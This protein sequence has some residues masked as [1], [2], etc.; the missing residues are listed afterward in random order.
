[1][2]TR[3]SI[4]LAAAFAFA[5][6]PSMVFA[7]GG[8]SHVKLHIN[9]RWSECSFQLDPSLTQSAWTKFTREA[10]LVAYFRSLT[11]A[12]PIGVGNFELSMHRWGTAVNDADPAW[13][14][15]FV[16]PDSVHWLKEGDR[17]EFP[18]LTF[19]TGLA[20]NV[21]IG[22]YW[23]KNPNA[24]Y[25][26]FGGQVQYAFVDNS[27]ENWAASARMSFMS[28]YGPGDLD[29]S[30]YGVELVASR[31]YAVFSDWISVS[32]YAGISAYLTR[33]HEKTDAVTLRDESTP[34]VRGIVGAVAQVSMARLAVEYNLSS[35]NSL[36]LKIGIGF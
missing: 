1:M 24:N 11:T 20:A 29:L 9:P 17:L 26:F 23:A 22:A 14:D 36:S 28:L 32:P 2:K 8:E 31:E 7:H 10:G 16:H 4:A 3:M 18:G 21:D 33:S 25:G 27:E 5:F 12:K 19:R 15:T 6:L 30:V 34:G 35:V 13:N